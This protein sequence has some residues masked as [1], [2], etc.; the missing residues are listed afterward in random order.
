MMVRQ[1]YLSGKDSMLRPYQSPEISREDR[2]LFDQLVPF[3]HWLRQA[4]QLIDFQTLRRLIEPYYRKT[5]GAPGVEPAVLVK[6]ALVMFHDNLSDGQAWER[7]KTDLSYRWF[8][9]LGRNDHLPERTV[10]N[11]FRAR[12]GS[13]GFQ[14]LFHAVLEQAR[15]H[16][17]VRDRLRIKDATH[18]VAN[19]AVAAGLNLLAQARNRLL[20]AAEPFDSETVAGERIKIESVRQRTDKDSA[21]VRLAARVDHLRDILSWVD[22]LPTPE[23]AEEN[24]RW[25]SLAKAREIAR[26]ALNGHDDPAQPDKLRG[27]SDPDARRGRHGEFYDGYMLDVMIDAD[28]ELFTAINVLPAS[29]NESADTLTLV[30]QEI[31]AHGNQLEAISI[32]G[33]GFDGAMLRQLQDPDGRNVKAFVP[34]R[35]ACSTSFAPEDFQLSDDGLHVTCP[36]GKQSQYRQRDENRTA[37]VFRFAKAE[38]DACLLRAQCHTKSQKFG[39]RVQKSDY[40]A[41]HAQVKERAKTQEYASIKKEH[42]TVDRKLGHLMNRY[43]GRRARYRGQARVLSQYF[44]TALTANVSRMI[45]LLVPE[46]KMCILS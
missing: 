11:K 29:G 12:L 20:S 31:L 10:M 33:A 25:Q 14:A 17:L 35:E 5:T 30:D 23:N 7:V 8:L 15:G 37:S 4:E 9:G 39:R 27:V 21:D 24:H 40:A 38:C 2:Q 3:D 16:G 34:S 26:K 28:S 41:E 18:V 46:L 19:I 42:P 45:K 32:D 13:E 43:C 44:M 6:L 22:Q 36:A 1:T